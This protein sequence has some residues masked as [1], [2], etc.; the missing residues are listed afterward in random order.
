MDKSQVLRAFCD[1]FQEFVDDVLRVF[2]RDAELRA[3]GKALGLMRKMNPR[4]IPTVFHDRIG[5]PYAAEIAAGDPSFFIEK[6]WG[7]DVV[8]SEDGILSKQGVLDKIDRMR[9]A[10]RRMDQDNLSKAIQY[11]RNLARLSELYCQK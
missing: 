6:N 10:L 3:V 4:V 1:H 2:P 5:Q 9:G 8:D 11:M 7:D